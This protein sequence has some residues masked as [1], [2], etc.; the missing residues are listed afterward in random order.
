MR[1]LPNTTTPRDKTI[2]KRLLRTRTL[3]RVYAG[4]SS[5]THVIPLTTDMLGYKVGEF[6]FTKN[7]GR[8]IHDSERNKKRKNK[9]KNKK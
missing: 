5:N 8:Q 6:S 3:L 2:T 4:S 7:L 1:N 9:N